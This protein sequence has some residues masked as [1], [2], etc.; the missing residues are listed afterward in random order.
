MMEIS[1]SFYLR[2]VLT[3]DLQKIMISAKYVEEKYTHY[4]FDDVNIDFTQVYQVLDAYG[5]GKYYSIPHLSMI[6]SF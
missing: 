5:L 3:G 4:F 1:D 6:P 2:N